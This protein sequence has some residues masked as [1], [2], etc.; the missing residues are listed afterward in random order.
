M[1][2]N[3]KI[4]LA[5][6]LVV[7]GCVVSN[8]PEGQKKP[9]LV[10]TPIATGCDTVDLNGH[11]AN[12]SRAQGSSATYAN[13]KISVNGELAY[14]QEP[15][16][17]Y[18]LGWGYGDSADGDSKL[19]DQE[20][21]IADTGNGVDGI[22]AILADVH[23]ANDAGKIAT[24]TVDLVRGPDVQIPVQLNPN[25]N[26]FVVASFDKSRFGN[27]Q[28]QGVKIHSGD[29]SLRLTAGITYELEEHECSSN[30]GNTASNDSVGGGGLGGDQG[31]GSVGLNFLP[32]A[33]GE[34]LD[35]PS[36][37]QEDLDHMSD[38]FDPKNIAVL[39]LAVDS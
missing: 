15:E 31:T 9:P 12:E 10:Q 7:A 23:P 14:G 28:I 16:G 25:S 4:A 35:Y 29:A 1:Q 17:L 20:I 32:A 27:V 21:K 37:T 22:T 8:A 3:T 24:A 36:I 6:G 5:A 11:F 38:L 30:D 13:V 33:V 2:T 18:S 39:E 26:G 19:I 34:S